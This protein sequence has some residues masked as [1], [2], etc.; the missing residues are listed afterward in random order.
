LIL[1]SSQTDGT[2]HAVASGD[3]R[4]VVKTISQ[5]P[6]SYNQAPAYRRYNERP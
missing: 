2:Y 6:S 1:F 3:I 5:I 4:N